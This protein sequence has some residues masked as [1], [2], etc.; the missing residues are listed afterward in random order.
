M[1]T[2]IS[3]TL[4]ACGTILIAVPPAS[5]YLLREQV[6]RVMTQKPDVVN[7]FLGGQMSEEYRIACWIAGAAMIAVSVFASMRDARRRREVEFAP[8]EPVAT[9]S[10]SE[11]WKTP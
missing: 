5:D 8:R 9:H 4:I 10:G 3:L 11:P 7:V 1:K 6:T 2:E